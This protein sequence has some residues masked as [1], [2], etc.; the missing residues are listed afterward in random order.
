MPQ[1]PTLLGAT[2]A[3]KVGMGGVFFDHNSQGFVWRQP[4]P[5]EVQDRLVSASNPGGSITNSNLEHAGLLGQVD[6]MVHHRDMRCAT[7]WNASD[8][9]P[10]SQPSD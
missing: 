6:V 3:A 9:T 4:F 2:D 7:I 8:N 10:G 1:E 5:Q